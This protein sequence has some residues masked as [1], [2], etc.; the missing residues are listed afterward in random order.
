MKIHQSYWV[1]SMLKKILQYQYEML[2]DHIIR[3]LQQIDV[4]KMYFGTIQSRIA[5]VSYKLCPFNTAHLWRTYILRTF[6]SMHCASNIEIISI[7]FSFICSTDGT[8][9]PIL[10]D[11]EAEGRS[12]KP[13]VKYGELVILGW[14]LKWIFNQTRTLSFKSKMVACNQLKSTID[15]TD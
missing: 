4:A 7:F 5:F 2:V 12:D 3:M 14:V 6:F 1:L 10:A 15:C 11:P 9:S 8:E 13:K